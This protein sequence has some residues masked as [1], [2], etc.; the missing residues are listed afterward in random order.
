[1][2]FEWM[3]WYLYLSLHMQHASLKIC[4]FGVLRLTEISGFQS[5]GCERLL[6]LEMEFPFYTF[7]SSLFQL[8]SPT[9]RRWH[10]ER[11]SSICPTIDS[12]QPCWAPHVRTHQSWY[13]HTIHL[14]Q[15][16]VNLDCIL[17]LSM[18]N[19]PR[20]LSPCHHW[21]QMPFPVSNGFKFYIT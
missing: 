20:L 11:S 19:L 18:L 16:S 10:R 4:S 15:K 9:E 13:I 1:M 12:Q 8:T 21:C 3:V 5:S 14:L 6:S 7:S 17:L 2:C